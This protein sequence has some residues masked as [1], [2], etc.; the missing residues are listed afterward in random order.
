MIRHPRILALCGLALGATLAA[1]QQPGDPAQ[2]QSPQQPR[3]RAGANLVRV[4]AYVTLDGE[5]VTN[6]A[7]PDFEVLE[8]NVPQRIESFQLI[9]PRG[10]GPANTLREPNTVAESREMARNPEARL[11]VLF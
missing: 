3:F 11:F 2:N 5:P 4:D 7:L 9:Q 10:P 6:L 8:D 1:A